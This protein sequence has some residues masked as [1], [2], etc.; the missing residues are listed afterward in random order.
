MGN[1]TSK[2]SDESISRILDLLQHPEQID[3]NFWINNFS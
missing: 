3:S 1:G 2:G